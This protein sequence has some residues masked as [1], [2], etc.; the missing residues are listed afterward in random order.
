MSDVKWKNQI[1][2]STPPTKPTHLARRADVLPVFMTQAEFAALEDPPGSNLYPTLAGRR[3]VLTDVDTVVDSLEMAAP[4]YGAEQALGLTNGQTWTAPGAGWF[5]YRVDIIA[6]QGDTHATLVINGQTKAVNGGDSV[7]AKYISD[8]VQVSQGDA[9]ALRATNSSGLVSTSSYSAFFIPPKF[10][11]IAEPQV[12]EDFLNV[13]MVPDYANREPANLITEDGGS[14]TANRDGYVSACSR[15]HVIQYSATPVGAFISAVVSINGTRAALT[16]SQGNPP[17]GDRVYASGVFA[18]KKG[19]VVTFPR[20]DSGGTPLAAENYTMDSFCYFIPPKFITV[21]APNIVVSGASYSTTEQATGET[22]IDGKPIYRRAFTGTIT[23]AVNA[24][25][26]TQ[27]M[28]Q[29]SSQI[30]WGGWL[31]SGN[32]LTRMSVGC[33]AAGDTVT[34][35]SWFNIN[36]SNILFLLS[37]SNIER[38]GDDKSAYQIWVEYTKP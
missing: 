20:G 17:V 3:V 29:V 12:S 10:V 4:D 13:A 31:C 34:F 35:S 33:V 23:A 6:G 9:V 36:P 30:R 2:I 38:L 32:D 5:R 27:L 24:L 21:Q 15:F 18:V 8:M 19:D 16:F 7:D 26:S 37:R 22:W 1:D 14:W 25:I 11:S 28:T